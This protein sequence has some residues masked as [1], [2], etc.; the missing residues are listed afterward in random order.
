MKL[1]VLGSAAGGGFPQ[2]N[3]GCPRCAG[4]RSGRLRA[5]P[6]TQASIAISGNERDWYLIGAT[7]EIRS[8]IESFAALH[9]RAPRHTPLAGIVLLNGDLDHTLGLLSLREWSQLTIHATRLV[10][11]GFTRDN[12]LN[13]AL[14]RYDGHSTWVAMTPG[15][16][17]ELAGGLRVEPVAVPGK[18]PLYV[19]DADGSAAGWN[20]GVRITDLGS[21]GSV[22]YF[23][24]VARIDAALRVSLQGLQALFFDGT[25]WSETE[26]I[27]LDLARVRGRDMG[28]VPV[29]GPDGSLQQLRAIDV[30]Q[31]YFIHINNSNPLL[32]E[33]SAEAAE[34]ASS[35]WKLAED[36]LELV[37]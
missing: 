19:R 32:D 15:V 35:G 14:C 26:L 18:A 23:P 16:P 6:R 1:R 20:L 11:E 36:G 24:G 33:D 8:Q 2:W 13:R 29:G 21:G 25:L 9:P 10:T 7:P 12:V 37:L 30:P 4:V 17:F 3:C 31:R 5:R 34:L 22:G 27:D 28:H